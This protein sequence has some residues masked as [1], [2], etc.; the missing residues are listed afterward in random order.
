MSFV[1][2]TKS[3]RS[4]AMKPRS[5][6]AA[7]I[8]SVSLTA[9]Q[10][11]DGP[12]QGVGTLVGAGLGALAGS[13]IGS[14]KG[15]LAAVAIGAVL[16]GIMGSEVGKS[17]DKA[18]RDHLDKTTQNSLEHNRVGQASTWRNPDSG[19]TGTVT[20]VSTY[21][22]DDGQDCREFSQTI[23]VD[24]KDEQAKGKACRQSDGTWRIVS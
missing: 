8:L 6:A 21:K 11:A 15:Q 4:K 1:K 17:L 24:G 3:T 19:N 13:Q 9:C 18:D 14:G 20:P 10:T 16:G 12:K 22:S 23:T 7:F 2:F 5:I